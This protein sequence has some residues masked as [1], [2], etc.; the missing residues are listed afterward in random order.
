MGQKNSKDVKNMYINILKN[1]TNKYS[2]KFISCQ[3]LIPA[4]GTFII[5]SFSKK[6]TYQVK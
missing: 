4:N 3:D 2:S 6:A 1:D 5:P